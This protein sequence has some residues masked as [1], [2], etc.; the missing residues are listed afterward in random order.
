MMSAMNN[1][2][3]VSA[4]IHSFSMSPIPGMLSGGSSVKG[5]ISIT[6]SLFSDCKV[7]LARIVDFLIVR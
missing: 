2:K 5:S 1:E 7:V 3:S 4:P 6:L